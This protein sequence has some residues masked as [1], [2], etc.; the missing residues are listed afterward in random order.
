MTRARRKELIEQLEQLRG[1]KVLAYATSDR[2][3]ASGQIG[4][5]AVRPLYD[6]LRQMGHVKK[7]DLFLYST[8]GAIDV[9]WR[10][11][12]ALRTTAD[13]WH[14]LIPFRA[15]SAATLLALGADT[16]VLGPQGE[17][18]PIDPILTLQRM[19]PVPGGGQSR[20]QDM[21]SVED[22]MAYQRFVMERAGLSDQDAL[23]VGLHKL[24]DRM[25]ALTIGSLYR[26][27]QHIRD[28]ARLMLLSRKRPANE[29]TMATIVETLAERVYAHGHAI[30]LKD[31]Q[32]IGLLAKAATANEDAAMWNLLN[33]YE[34]DMKI[35]Q[36][37][38]P[39]AATANTDLYEEDCI[40]AIIES[41]WAAS[42]HQGRAEVRAK[43][44][45]PQ[46]FNLALNVALQLPQGINVNQLPAALQQ[47]LQA[48]QQQIVQQA[49]QAVD[50]AMK[51]QAPVVGL[52]VGLRD[53]RWV[54]VV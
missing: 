47:A 12:T 28:V 35:L 51:K 25:D 24:T 22:V 17:L 7:L 16:I 48:A 32:A 15:N 53:A 19:V 21:I 2:K 43:R 3:P 29:Q 23:A 52:E 40:V 39:A 20:M 4:D 46:N 6:H 26:T 37:I 31:A 38:D 13:E 36:T 49:Q 50:A 18:G 8:G 54:T 5:D 1:S 42:E 41:A 33:E 45:M 30:G 14:V 10:I 9:P 44:Q 27:H 34:A 11:V